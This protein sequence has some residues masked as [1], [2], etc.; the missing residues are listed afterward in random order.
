MRKL[1]SVQRIWE[2]SNIDNADNLEK[3]RVMGW[4]CVARKGDFKRGDLCLYIEIDSVCPHENPIFS[5]LEQTRYRVKTKKLRGVISQ[6]L[7]LKLSDFNIDENSVEIGQ[8][9]AEQI[10]IVKYE[11]NRVLNQQEVW[12][13]IPHYIQKTDQERIQNLSNKTWE[14]YKT[15]EWEVTEKI[16]G[17]SGTFGF[18]NGEYLTASRNQQTK[19]SEGSVWKFLTDK[20]DLENKLKKLNKNIAIQGE[21]IG[22]KIQGNIY[23]LREP[24]LKIFDIWDIDNQVYFNSNERIEILKELELDKLLVPILAFG[25]VLENKTVEYIIDSADGKS[26]L[27]TQTN[28]EGLVF[29]C[30]TNTNYHFKAV[31]NEYLLKQN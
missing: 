3:V 17:Q 28:R 9:F 6:G 5:M 27:N 19:Q 26:K 13:N 14:L 8:D 4:Q 20:Y 21:V 18:F 15:L 12:G 7:C 16:E 10:G 31:S 22:P 24:D 30:L 25:K 2:V 11:D 29:K 23:K 1:A